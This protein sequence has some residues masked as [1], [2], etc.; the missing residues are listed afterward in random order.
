MSFNPIKCVWLDKSIM[1]HIDKFLDKREQYSKVEE[2][3]QKVI[4]DLNDIFDVD[5]EFMVRKKKGQEWGRTCCKKCKDLLYIE[6]SL[7]DNYGHYT[8]NENYDYYDPDS[9]FYDTGMWCKKC[10]KEYEK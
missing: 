8:I 5:W 3:R 2:K 6:W 1:K 9:Y 4:E 10:I 7:K